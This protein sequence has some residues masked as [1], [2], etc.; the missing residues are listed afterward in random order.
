MSVRVMR[1]MLFLSSLFY[2]MD[3]TI[4]RPSPPLE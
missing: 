1:E 3:L 4:K 2:S